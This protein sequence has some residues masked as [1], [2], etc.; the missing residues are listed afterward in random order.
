MAS[1]YRRFISGFSDIAGPLHRLTQKG[2]RFDWDKNCQ[3]AFE[4]LKEQLISNPVL[5]FPDL[6]GDYIL[7]TDASD[8]GIGAVLTQK[9]ENYDEEEKVVSFAF[10]AFSGA[11]KNWTTTEKEAFAVV[12]ALQYFHPYVYGR[13]VTI[14]TD[15]NA[16]KWLR[17]IKHPNGKLA[18]WILKLEEYDYTIEHLPNTKMQH[19][20]AL[21]RAPVNT[22]LVSMSTWQEFEDMQTFDEDIQLVSRVFLDQIKNRL[23]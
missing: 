15:H 9:D 21:S 8:V 7:Y 1:Y 17:D 4:Q 22:I 12:W 3:R 23:M 10:S 20:D 13:K 14:Y 2:V 19:A 5:A 11:E 18:R 16:L 6:N